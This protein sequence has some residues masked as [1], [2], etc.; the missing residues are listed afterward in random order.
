[1][2]FDLKTSQPKRPEKQS[3]ATG[4]EERAEDA[5]QNNHDQYYSANIG[6]ILY[7]WQA[8]EFEV[9]EKSGRWYIIATLFIAAMIIYALFTNA[10]IM[11]ITFIL[12]GIVGYIYTKRNPNIVTFVITSKGILAN[13]EMYLYENINSFWI[14]YEPTHTKVISLHTKAS[15][16]PFVHIP[17]RDENPVM[18]RSILLENIPEIKQD[19]S[20]IDT[21]EKVLHI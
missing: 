7:S 19:P 8:P 5:G 14:F 17:F 13:K 15:M 6:E 21:I 2:S 11:A 12:L 1:M 18:L 3:Y 16:L 20:L 9:Y 10:P 4:R